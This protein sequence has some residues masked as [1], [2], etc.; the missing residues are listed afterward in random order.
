MNL[1]V[2][3]ILKSKAKHEKRL[4]TFFERII[5]MERNNPIIRPVSSPKVTLPS[6]A[7]LPALPEDGDN[8]RPASTN[9]ETANVLI[10][11]K[12]TIEELHKSVLERTKLL[13]LLCSDYRD[14][15]PLTYL[16]YAQH[17]FPFFIT[18]DK[19]L[20]CI[21]AGSKVHGLLVPSRV[22]YLTKTACFCTSLRIAFKKLIFLGGFSTSINSTCDY[23]FIISRSNC[24]RVVWLDF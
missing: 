7:A 13:S 17:K 15:E 1:S 23:T 3:A 12:Q 2:Q 5:A 10:N 20:M 6:K 9:S 19:E 4:W 21:E 22:N 11:V 18:K 24:Q 14:I 16:L 8:P